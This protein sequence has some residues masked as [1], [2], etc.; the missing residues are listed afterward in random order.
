MTVVGP[1]R[2]TLLQAADLLPWLLGGTFVWLGFSGRPAFTLAGSLVVG[3]AG[4]LH[5]ASAQG[6]V[7]PRLGRVR[8]VT[9]GCCETPLAFFVRHRGHA[10][11]FHR[12]KAPADSLPES[13][14]VIALPSESDGETI[15]WSGFEPPED[16]RF[17][18]L[19]P[20]GDLR[21]EHRGGD[22]VDGASLATV[23]GRLSV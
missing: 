19:V 7:V 11:L 16:S 23:L 18:G 22:Y 10:F 20:V 14:C 2:R 13:Y 12:A 5:L 3:V 6:F 4:V 9:Q 15:R 1:T 21:F 8:I 17:L